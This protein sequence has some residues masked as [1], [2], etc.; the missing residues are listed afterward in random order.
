MFVH[1]CSTGFH[2]AIVRSFV[3]CIYCLEWF[4]IIDCDSCTKPISTNLADTEAG[5]LRLTRETC[6]VAGCSELAAVT[7]LCFWGPCRCVCFLMR[8]FF[9][10]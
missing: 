5:E 6:F 1:V 10:F 7:V 3:S 2:Y 8:F 4:F 9:F